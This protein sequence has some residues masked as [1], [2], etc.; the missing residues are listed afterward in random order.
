MLNRPIW[1]E[2]S[3]LKNHRL[4]ATSELIRN[5]NATTEKFSH[6]RRYTA[7]RRNEMLPRS[8][9]YGKRWL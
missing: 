1:I 2:L 5:V 9:K 6:V 8:L 4:N 3:T 7:R